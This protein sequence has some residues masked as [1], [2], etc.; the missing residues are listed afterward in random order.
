MSSDKLSVSDINRT[1][2]YSSQTVELSGAGLGTTLIAAPASLSFEPQ[3]AGGSSSAQSVTVTNASGSTVTLGNVGISANFGVAAGSTCKTGT[4][5][6]AGAAC[7]VDVVFSPAAGGNLTGSLTLAGASA[8]GPEA[9]VALAGTGEDFALT[10]PPPGTSAVISAGQTAAYNLTLAPAGGLNEPIAVAC[11]LA[12]PAPAGASC[13]VTPAQVTPSGNSAASVTVSIR[14][15]SGA[16]APPRLPAAPF[17]GSPA[18]WMLLLL[19]PLLIRPALRRR[20]KPLV[21]LP[22]MLLMAALA[23]A[24]GGGGAAAVT[25]APQARATPA[26]TYYATVSATCGTLVHQVQLTITV[27]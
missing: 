14:T 24:C 21:A 6:P 20:R 19:T 2:A 18:A 12:A 17:S 3:L 7:T 15:S 22:A 1:V 10:A 13:F 23:A 9:S 27:H 26:G 8:G 11:S 4:A 25:T 16:A 5:L